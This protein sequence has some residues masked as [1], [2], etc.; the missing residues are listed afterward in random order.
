[1]AISITEILG[2]DSLSASRLVLNDNFNILADEINAME[3]YFDPSSGI[4]DSLTS[5]QTEALRVG[6]SSTIL[7]INSSTFD[8]VSDIDITGDIILRGS[9][10]R[11]D[12]ESTSITDVTTAP[13]FI[14]DIG[15]TT[16]VP[17]KTVYRMSNAGTSPMTIQLFEGNVG[18][19]IFFI[20]EGG[21]SGQIDI[22]G[23]PGTTFTLDGGS[24]ITMSDAGQTVHM[25]C[26]TN[27]VGNKEW[28]IIG[29]NGYIV[30]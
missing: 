1:M 6:I 28:Y 23:G 16:T 2:T 7:E 25:L 13:S 27:S 12:I 29:G 15:S 20:Y 10:L 19:E 9:L 8:I 4:I 21:G 14:Q 26:I 3:A 30:S 11:N 24:T 5:L 17:D 22:V 18:Q